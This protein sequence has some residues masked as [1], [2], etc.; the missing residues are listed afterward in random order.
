MLSLQNQH[1]LKPTNICIS[2]F[3]AI[4]LLSSCKHRPEQNQAVFPA[5]VLDYRYENGQ[6]E[7]LFAQA[8]SLKYAQLYPEA[9]DAFLA[10]SADQSLSKE[11][12]YYLHNQLADL[13]LL[14]HD[15]EGAGQHVS[16]LQ[17]NC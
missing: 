12:G 15:M 14:R 8:D 7:G 16:V 6:L 13:Y 9:I 17:V 11:D 2:F 10:L 1:T 4:L 5:S 3:A